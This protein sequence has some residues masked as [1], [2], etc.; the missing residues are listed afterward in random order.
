MVEE[1]LWQ[2]CIILSKVLEGN[3]KLH[4]W[5]FS[6]SRGM[7]LTLYTTYIVDLITIATIVML[8]ATRNGSCNTRCYSLVAIAI[9]STLQIVSCKHAV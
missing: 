7:G 8:L 2:A 6:Q 9:P 3:R 4:G 5:A 1:S